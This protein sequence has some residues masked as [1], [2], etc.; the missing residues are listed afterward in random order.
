MKYLYNPIM[1][2]VRKDIIYGYEDLDNNCTSKVTGTL[3]FILRG[4][5]YGMEDIL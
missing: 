3:V 1:C 2:D 4:I 5:E